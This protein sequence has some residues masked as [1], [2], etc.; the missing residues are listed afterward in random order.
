[1]TNPNYLA[2]KIVPKDLEDISSDAINNASIINLP[3]QYFQLA[4]KL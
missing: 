3:K 2:I 1:M 4:I